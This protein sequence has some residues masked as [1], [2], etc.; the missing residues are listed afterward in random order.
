MSSTYIRLVYITLFDPPFVELG[1]Q[2]LLN[3]KGQN[4]K[5]QDQSKEDG[6][7]GTEYD[8]GDVFAGSN[9]DPDF[10][11]LE[12]FYTK[13]IFTCEMDGKP[14][15]CASCM[16]WKPDRSHHCTNSGRCVKKMDHFCPWYA[17][18]MT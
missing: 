18:T 7:G 1:E 3:K 14:R 2:A 11:G 5:D 13:D 9:N 4:A 15:W 12:L 17:D 10:P 8:T 16:N 6:I